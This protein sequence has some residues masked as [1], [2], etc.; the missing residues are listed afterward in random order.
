MNSDSYIC[1]CYELI[2]LCKVLNMTDHVIYVAIIY[3]YSYKS[4]FRGGG[5]GPADPAAA[6]PKIYS[7][8]IRTKNYH[9]NIF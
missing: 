3:R 5:T 8:I 6:G 9:K 1:Y 4:Q 2:Q 7:E